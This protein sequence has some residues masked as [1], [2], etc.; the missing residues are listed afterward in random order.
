MKY[1]LPNQWEQ[2]LTASERTVLSAP[3]TANA[4]VS[5]VELHRIDASNAD[6]FSK[7]LNDRINRASA[8]GFVLVLDLSHLESI[9]SAG[10]RILM[11]ARR[12]SGRNAQF[13]LAAPTGCVTEQLKISGLDEWFSVYAD[14]DG[15]L[16]S[17]AS[18]A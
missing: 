16:R 6:D 1:D 10:M 18:A 14:V 17:I 13:V 5:S 7:W 15:A 3:A 8:C 4:M 9:S 2:D 11:S 12:S